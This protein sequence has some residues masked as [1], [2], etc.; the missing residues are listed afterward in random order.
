MANNYDILTDEELCALAVKND[1]LSLTVLISR[2]TGVVKQTARSYFL[3]GG[4][5]EDL[6]QEGML[7]LL[8]AI[9]SY[10]GQIA[11]KPY[12]SLCIRRNIISA[13]KM[14]NGNKHKILN[15]SVDF[16]GGEDFNAEDFLGDTT[17]EPSELFEKREFLE[18]TRVKLKKILSSFEY[19]VL[20]LYLDGY[21]YAEISAKTGK[22]FK[23]I[24]NAI[25]RIRKK[26]ET[27]YDA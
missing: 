19:G 5:V 26:V 13:V 22:P 7:G 20:T 10:N 24:D 18:E 2:Y 11:F 25:Q 14:A 4:D 15:T 6:V 16:D 9:K 27:K 8:K 3:F 21:T 1:D 12:A 23:S 17:F